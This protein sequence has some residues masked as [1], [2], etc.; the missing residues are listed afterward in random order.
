M[1]TP[2]RTHRARNPQADTPS[3][4][5]VGD[6]QA[7][8]LRGRRH[9]RRTVGA[10]CLHER[11]E[12][13]AAASPQDEALV[14]GT[15]RITYGE[16]NRRANR[17]AHLLRSLG[18]G[19]EKLVGVHLERSV[20]MIA[21]LLGV[22]KSG[23]AYLPLDPTY[24]RERLS[25]ML[26]DARTPV[27][28]TQVSLADAMTNA[29]P[30]SVNPVCLDR[31]ARLAAASTENPEPLALPRNLAYVI[32]TSGSSGQPK[33]VGLEHRNASALLDWA[34]EL[35][36]PRELAGV[37]AGISISFD[38]SIMDIFLPLCRGGRVI[39][40]P[41]TLAMREQAAA[42]EVRMFFAVPSVVREL[43]RSGGI[44]ASVETIG[45]GGEPLSVELVRELYALPHVRRVYDLYGPTETTTCSTFALR[46]A[47]GPA[48]IGRAIAR[49]QVYL[50]DEQL[51]PVEPG[52][53]GELCIGGAGVARGYLDRPALTAERFV[54]LRLASGRSVRVYRTGDLGRWQPDG[55]LEYRGR[56]DQQV[57]IRGFRIELGE[58]ESALRAHPE[59]GEAVVVA[60]EIAPGRKGLA[61]YVVPRAA[62]V[63]E[64][65]PEQLPFR[66]RE[67]LCHRLPDFMLPATFTLLE[68]FALSVNGKIDREN[69]PAPVVDRPDGRA[70]VAPRTP[71]ETALCRLWAEALRRPEIGVDDDFIA[72]GGDSL[73]GVELL[74]AIEREFGVRLPADAIVRAPTV[75]RLAGL[76]VGGSATVSAEGNLVEIQR[77]GARPRLFLV[78]GVGGGMLWGYANLA[79]HLRPD[80]PVMAFRSAGPAGDGSFETIEEM[81]ARYAAELRRFQPAGPYCIGG[82]CFGGNVAYEMARILEAQGQR[83]HLV[84]L[85]NSSPP[86]SS[87]DEVHWHPLAL[88]RFCFNLVYWLKRFGEWEPG[89]RRQFLRWKLRAV[90]RKLLGLVRRTDGADAEETDQHVDLSVIPAHERR[91]WELHVKALRNHRLGTAKYR[92]RVTLFRTRGHPLLCSFDRQCAWGEYAEGGVDVRIISGLHETLMSDPHVRILARELQRELDAVA[93]EAEL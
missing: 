12:A 23:G 32:Y 49:T 33:G 41:N 65:L 31:E 72:L 69:L 71:V 66:L 26:R 9:D 89:I 78:H 74:V 7:S 1:I 92:G 54:H 68:R 76:L 87:Y 20:D 30:P 8:G 60:R 86:N 79:R 47:D 70:F 3:P 75:A 21:A 46:R 37:L 73:L 11:F 85:L 18:V 22:L 14:S 29:L 40:A 77:G 55:M 39:L 53:T 34:G 91:T 88:A 28:L 36:S 19:P 93:A 6:R 27:V 2:S 51:R 45:L 17:I 13:H 5:L 15:T 24:P 25:F 50:L 10:V 62:S 4:V 80:Q 59:V 44:P 90:R 61:A 38:P 82:Y 64:T 84:A 35:F 83:V 43:L 58:I 67:H 48:T 42:D 52:A 63:P 57:K 81:G 56:A 16:L